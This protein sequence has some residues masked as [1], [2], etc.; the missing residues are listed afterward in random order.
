MRAGIKVKNTDKV[1]KKLQ[2]LPAKVTV[3]VKKAVETS[4]LLVEGTAKTSIQ[5]GPKSG[6][7]YVRQNITHQ[8]SASG[9][10]PATDTGALASSISHWF[11]DD[12]LSV[13]IG[14]YLQYARF[15]EYGTVNMDARPFLFPSVESNRQAIRQMFADAIKKGVAK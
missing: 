2:Q 15:L 8:A 10:A 13:L 12:G 7:I 3:E 5:R 1:I 9:E 6:E 14:S 4:A 11:K